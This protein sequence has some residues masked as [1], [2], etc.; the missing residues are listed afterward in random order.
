MLFQNSCVVPF[1]I[2]AIVS[3]FFAPAP[4][5]PARLQLIPV[6]EMSSTRRIMS[7]RI[8]GRLPLSFEVRE[9][10]YGAAAL[11]ESDSDCARRK[12]YQKRQPLIS[13][14]TYRLNQSFRTG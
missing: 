14:R 11:I 7:F 12:V 6:T 9:P 13:H 2:T 3:F 8:S 4:G 10:T 1:G 5:W